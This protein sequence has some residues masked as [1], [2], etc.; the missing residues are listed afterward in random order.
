[1]NE[2][3][4]H[5]RPLLPDELIKLGQVKLY[6]ILYLAEGQG[7]FQLDGG[8]YQYSAP[9]LIFL[10]PFQR[11]HFPQSTKAMASLLEFHGDFYCIE[12]HKA[13]VAC[14]GLLFNNIFLSPH[15]LLTPEDA[16]QIEELFTKIKY[17]LKFISSFDKS[18]MTAYLQLL[19]AIASRMKTRQLAR[20]SL[21][22]SLDEKMEEFKRLIDSRF[23]VM[24]KPSDYA[25]ALRMRSNELTKRCR[26]AFGKTPS[27]L[28][29]ER[30]ILEAK[31]K[32][33]LTRLSVK[34]VAFELNFTDEHYFSRYFKKEVGYSP[35]KFRQLAG[36]SIVADLSRN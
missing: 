27:S 35:L 7:S 6:S 32:L 18:V 17:E 34:E 23:L 20:Y 11:I 22:S 13:E 19:L 12:F 3:L 14:N 4:L 8:V 15:I 33:H 21:L 30:I 16:L 29:N 28:I 26:K 9:L 25:Q 10:A 36:I 31:K 1:M 24:Q 2:T 5:F